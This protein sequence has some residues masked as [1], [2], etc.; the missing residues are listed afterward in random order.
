MHSQLQQIKS[1][2]LIKKIITIEIVNAIF[3]LNKKNSNFLENNTLARYL[4]PE[5]N[6]KQLP[7]Y[8]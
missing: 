3:F 4:G 5:S 7:L 8:S 1:T 6:Q 2:G